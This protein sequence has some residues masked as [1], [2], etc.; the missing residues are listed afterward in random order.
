MDLSKVVVFIGESGDT[1]YEGF[2]G[3]VQKSIVLKGIGGSTTNLLH[4]NRIYPLSDVTPTESTNTLHTAEDFSAADIRTSLEKL[5]VL[6][7]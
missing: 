5:G 4:A 7:A 3:G 6:K 2:L 1:D